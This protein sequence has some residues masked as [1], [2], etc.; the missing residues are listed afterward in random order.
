MGNYYEILGLP[1][2]ATPAE[3]KTAY[4]EL[5]K[6]YHP[7]KQMGKSAVAQKLAEDKF[8]QISQ[9]YE[10]LKN[11]EQRGDYDDEF[12]R[13]I[14][15]QITELVQHNKL[16][17]AVKVAQKL[18]QLFPQDRDC[19]NVY[20]ELTY[21][22]A[23]QFAELKKFNQAE[24]YLKSA[25]EIASDLDLRKKISIDLEVLQLQKHKRRKQIQAKIWQGLRI[26]ALGL[27]VA[28]LAWLGIAGVGAIQNSV[29]PSLGQGLL[30][31]N[32]ATMQIYLGGLLVLVGLILSGRWRL[33]IS[34]LIIGMT[35]WLVVSLIASGIA[36]VSSAIANIAQGGGAIAIGGIS[37][38]F[39]LILAK[40]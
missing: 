25:L 39:G 6:K 10:I 13:D 35:L 14:F 11:S 17:A 38:L 4:I 27:G 7:D 36:L 2:T 23:V 21:A 12:R 26:L 40:K 22:L 19:R 18:H 32:S 33:G 30:P 1:P 16:S 3:I 37:L 34:L 8:K 31:L 5:A 28:C 9:A 15:Q 29:L 24:T 20:G